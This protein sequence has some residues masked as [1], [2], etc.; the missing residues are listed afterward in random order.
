MDMGA[1]AVVVYEVVGGKYML[2]YGFKKLEMGSRLE[3]DV[4]PRS[5]C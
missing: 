5:Y 1:N 4:P 3:T 2:Q